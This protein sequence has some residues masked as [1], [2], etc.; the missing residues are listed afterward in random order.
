VLG[1]PG[2]RAL[3]LALRLAAL[4]DSVVLLLLGKAGKVS[5]NHAC[6]T[7]QRYSIDSCLR[8]MGKRWSII[9]FEGMPAWGKKQDLTPAHSLE[10]LGIR[11]CCGAHRVQ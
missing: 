4:S 8:L 5:V 1:P 7:E 3:R 2:N 10:E 6:L 9:W 11:A